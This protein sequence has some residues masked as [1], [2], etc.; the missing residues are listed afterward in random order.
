MGPQHR[1][2]PRRGAGGVLHAAGRPADRWRGAAG[3]RCRR[4]ALR[5]C[6][7]AGSR[8]APALLPASCEITAIQRRLAAMRRDHFGIGRLGDRGHRAAM[9]GEIFHLRRRRAGV[10]GHRNGAELDAGEPGQH[11]LDAVVEMDQHIFA[12]LD[13]ARDE[14]RGQRA[15]PLVKFAV[16][17]APRR[18]VER[19]PDQ[20]RMVAPR[21]GPHPQQPRHV[22][23]CERSDDA[24]RCL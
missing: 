4:T 7:R 13:A 22:E 10:G 2:R 5:N 15:D 16:R 1:L 24:R 19:R 12:G 18:R 11:G 14:P 21:L 9:T 17:P 20:E 3:R 8:L 23:P 6:R